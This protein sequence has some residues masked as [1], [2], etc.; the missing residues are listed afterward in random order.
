MKRSTTPTFDGIGFVNNRGVSK[1]WGVSFCKVNK[2]RVQ[3]NDSLDDNI[4]LSF[5]FTPT[6][7]LAAKVSSCLFK[8]R[9]AVLPAQI[10]I[11]IGS[12]S[13]LIKN[14][15]ITHLSKASVVHTN[16][17]RISFDG[18]KADLLSDNPLQFELPEIKSPT[19]KVAA[20]SS[21]FST[22]ET[23]LLQLILKSVEK[24]TLSPNV[25]QLI[26]NTMDIV[27]Q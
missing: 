13:L 15:K 10:M 12:V 7:L 8:Y 16:A 14:K 21:K 27:L 23:E 1:Y 6:E 5:D 20:M 22:H 18:L 4:T 25:A 2:W 11:S 26:R 17:V 3:V 9:N 19:P 24:D